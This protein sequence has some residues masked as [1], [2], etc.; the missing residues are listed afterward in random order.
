[1]PPMLNQDIAWREA[2]L[3]VVDVETTGLNGDEDR[4][5][6]IAIVHMR[7]DAVEDVYSTLVDPQRELP[8]EVT[9]ITGIKPEDL[10]GA[11]VFADIAAEV[12]RRLDGRAFVAY[13]LPFDKGFIV[14][15]L[16]RAG[17]AWPETVGIDPL[18]FVRE[19]HQNQGS[20]RLG[21]VAE[22]LGVTL[23]EAHRAAADAEAAGHVLF[24]LAE[25]LPERL[26][27]LVL[28]QRQWAQVQAN[29]M[30]SWRSRRGGDAFA[31]PAA[32][33]TAADRGNALGPAYIYGDDSDPVR[34]MFQHL[35]ASGTRR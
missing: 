12:A 20:K 6:E 14:H 27:D 25:Q 19:L 31:A 7:N 33:M 2:P 30:A 8:P 21:A 5:I 34:A 11:P 18:V 3:A 22:R 24:A 16:E 26:G 29:R 1:M 23:D 35:P 4:I 32:D 9:K 17:V 13:N 28:L 10:Q 15:E